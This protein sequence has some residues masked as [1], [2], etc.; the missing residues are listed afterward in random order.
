MALEMKERCSPSRLPPVC[1]CPAL[2]LTLYPLSSSPCG[3]LSAPHLT[4]PNPCTQPLYM[5][6]RLGDF[7][8]FGLAE[9]YLGYAALPPLMRNSTVVT[10]PTAPAEIDA[11][12]VMLLLAYR[13]S[14]PYNPFAGK[15]VEEER[16]LW[17]SRMK[18]CVAAVVF[19][20]FGSLWDG[21]AA[22]V[23][24]DLTGDRRVE[25]ALRDEL[26]PWK[27]QW[28]FEGVARALLY[29]EHLS[30]DDAMVLVTSLE[31]GVRKGI[32]D[33]VMMQLRRDG[34]SFGDRDTLMPVRVAERMAE[35]CNMML[36]GAF[37]WL[38]AA[39]ARRSG[40]PAVAAKAG[41][42]ADEDPEW[43]SL[44]KGANYLVISYKERNRPLFLTDGCL[45]PNTFLSLLEKHFVAILL[46]TDAQ[47]MLLP[48]SLARDV[49]RRHGRFFRPYL[50]AETVSK[51][52][53]STARALRDKIICLLLDFLR[54]GT[55][56]DGGL[57]DWMTISGA[58]PSRHS[59][60]LITI[61]MV[62]I[63]LAA[64]FSLPSFAQPSSVDSLKR[65]VRTGFDT[66]T[67]FM[68]QPLAA[69]LTQ[70]ASQPVNMIN[71]I[72]YATMCRDMGDRLLYLLPEGTKPVR[73]KDVTAVSTYTQP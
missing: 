33:A 3:P 46:L 73:N 57:V 41:A 39:A 51:A 5:K 70:L 19:S 55:E 8:K 15:K 50:A 20:P 40:T 63:V 12:N 29:S 25:P 21:G 30:A 42:G 66:I 60:A 23:A 37:K 59:L 38:L 58:R 34:V 27:G 22:A 56:S 53:E 11:L 32:I 62:R 14:P 1:P 65:A 61:R 35:D 17:V 43:E 18:S 9:R 2:Y 67:Q 54:L 48:A 69:F 44:R 24:A 6:D 10:A 47:G 31:A 72:A 49:H 36:C 4:P 52:R 71:R 16:V 13:S 7:K 28:S 68:P 45:S 64:T 26:L